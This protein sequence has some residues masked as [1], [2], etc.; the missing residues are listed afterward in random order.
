[1]RWLRAADVSA[2]TIQ[3]S[4]V[5]PQ[6]V[7][8]VRFHILHTLFRLVN[9]IEE[10]ILSCAILIIALVTIANVVSRTAFGRSLA[11]AEELAQ[12]CIIIVTFVGLSY[13]ASRD[14][15]IRMSALYDLSYRTGRKLL[16]LLIS[17]VTSAAMFLL[18]YYS[19]LYISSVSSLGTVSPV[20]RVP[21]FLV[22]CSVP[23]GFAL[24]GIQYALNFIRNLI[25]REVYVS[26]G[27]TEEKGGEADTR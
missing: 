19:V 13:A 12:F 22:Y 16:M 20:L 17:G 1:V 25:E 26:F 8:I 24:A 4:H 3:D 23:L 18:C 27:T 21:L 15:H 14:R 11:F 6:G 7:S 9:R 2:C 10:A 5:N